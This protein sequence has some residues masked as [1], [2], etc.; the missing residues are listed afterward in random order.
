MNNKKDYSAIY[1][2]LILFSLYLFG[3]IFS[4]NIYV[5]SDNQNA[6]DSLEIEKLKIQIEINKETLKQFK[7]YQN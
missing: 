3:V 4:K 6:I 1:V 7:S 5:K 2:T